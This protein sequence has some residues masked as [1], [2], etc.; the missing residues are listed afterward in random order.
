MM[1]KA[2]EIINETDGLEP[3]LD[4][5]SSEIRVFRKCL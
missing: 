3:Y 5:F 4:T 2:I 1:E